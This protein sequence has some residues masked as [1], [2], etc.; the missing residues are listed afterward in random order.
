MTKQLL[1]YGDI[2]AVTTKK[3]GKLSVKTGDNYDFARNI[4]SVPLMAAEFPP[5]SLEYTVVF[6]E[7][8]DTVMPVAIMGFRNE[9]NLYVGSDGKWLARYIPAFIRRYPFVFSSSDDGK[10]FTLCIDTE[11]AG[12]NQEDRGERLFDAD[13][14]QT[15]YLKNVLE[16]LKEYQVQYQRTQAFAKK[17]KE[18]DLLEPMTAQFTTQTGDKGNLTGFMAVNREKLKKLSGDQFR[19]LAQ[20]D[21]LE[22]IYIH[23]QSLQN[24]TQIITK[25]QQPGQQSQEVAPGAGAASKKT[26][27]KAGT[28][29]K[30]QTRKKAS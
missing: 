26:P 9:E 18:L 4:N 8:E 28:R 29:K 20:T 12:C 19:E 7:H 16:F 13:G 6:T 14:E 1:I 10:S 3:H 24:F 15:Q 2:Q 23:I 25:G 21:E 30:A 22:L 11:F 27:V 17:L 5:A